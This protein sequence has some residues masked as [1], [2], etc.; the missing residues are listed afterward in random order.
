MSNPKTNNNVQDT[1]F[2]SR[3]KALITALENN[4][5]VIPGSVVKGRQVCYHPG[6]KQ[7]TDPE[8][9]ISVPFDK[10]DKFF[11]ES[12]LRKPTNIDYSDHPYGEIELQSKINAIRESISVWGPRL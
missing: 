2:F 10:A 12:I 6:E 9:L 1:Y 4:Y 5:F 7:Q 8:N 3:E 11:S